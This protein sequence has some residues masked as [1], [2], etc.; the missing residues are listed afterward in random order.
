M[1]NIMMLSTRPERQ[2]VVQRPGELVSGVCID[3]LEKTAHDP[4]VHSQDV[5]IA[6][7]SAPCDR[8]E[9]CAGAQDHDFDGRGVLGCQTEGGGVVVM[10]LVDGAVERAPVHGAVGPVV[11]GVLDDEEDGDV[12]GDLPHGGE[13]DAGVHAE[14]DGHGVEDP[15]LGELDGEVGE[16]DHFGAV[17]LLCD[18]GDFALERCVLVRCDGGRGCCGADEGGAYGLDLVFVEVGHAVD[19]DPG[20]GAA[21]VDEFVHH[22]GHDS[23]REDVVLHV[24]V[25]GLGGKLAH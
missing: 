16:E 8:T 25:P 24:C 22:E 2:E 6:S 15:D 1:V 12:H 20:E 9:D 14:E 23:S 7:D 19:D 13:G 17:P 5:Q 18:G 3:S 10:D 11:P 4:E 21:E